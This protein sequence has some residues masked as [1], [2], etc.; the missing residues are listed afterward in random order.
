MMAV[1]SLVALIGFEPSLKT[2]GQKNA[3]SGSVHKKS[4]VMGLSSYLT[5]D[6]YPLV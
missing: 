5:V 3:S 2:A 6:R 1:E 4:P